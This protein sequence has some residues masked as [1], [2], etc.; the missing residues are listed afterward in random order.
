MGSA[1]AT[2][3]IGAVGPEGTHGH[4]KQYN[5]LEGK[6]PS[7]DEAASD[8]ASF[9]HTAGGRPFPPGSGSGN[10]CA[11]LSPWEKDMVKMPAELNI[12]VHT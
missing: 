8:P 10:C 11:L 1:L 3:D 7:R 9:I 4:S 12:S 5:I 2:E 6:G